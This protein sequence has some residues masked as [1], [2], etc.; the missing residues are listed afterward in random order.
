VRSA[1][2]VFFS[3]V[4]VAA[5]LTP[6]AAVAVATPAFADTSG[7]TPAWTPPVK[8][9]GGGA[10]PSIRVAPDGRTAAYIAAPSALGSNFWRVEESVDSAGITH[11]TPSDAQQP[12]L[13]TGGGD[14]EI[15]VGQQI[16]PTS[17]C[18]PIAYSGLHNIDLFDNFTV[19]TSTDCGKTFSLA[20]PFG[21]QNTLTDR[22]WQTFDGQLTNHL[23]YHKVDTGQI[24][25]SVS[26]DGG[27]TYV[28]L[29]TPAGATGLIDAAHA[30][31]I[32][33]V[34]IGNILTDESRPVSGKTYPISGEQVHTLWA[35]FAGSRDAADA[36]QGAAASGGWDHL[37]TIYVARSDDGGL[38]WTD[39]AAYTTGASETRELDLIFPV[40]TEDT[41]GNLYS[42]W[43][44]G[45]LIQYVVSTDA[46][47][48]WS[49]PYTVNPGESGAKATDGT[50]DLFPWIAGGGP[51][52]LDVVWYHGQGGDTTGYRNV[53]T[54]D[55]KW[56]VAFAQLAD[57]TAV[58]SAGAAAPTV[59]QR[60]LAVTP[61][62]H[63]GNV[64][65]N[66]TT[67]GITDNGDRT[68]LD[69]F[70]VAIDAAGRANIAYAADQGS[71]GTAHVEYTR[72]NS[73]QSV[74][75]G[76][77]ITPSAF[78]ADDGAAACT[79]DGTITD[80]AG[81][82]TGAVLVTSTPTPSQA[83]L[84]VTRAWI[85][86]TPATA[87]DPESLTFHI[88]VTNLGDTGGQ[89]FRFY[90]SYGTTQY[91]AIM[92]RDQTGAKAYS[93]SQNGTTGASSLKTITGSFD[94]AASEVTA[95]FRL[96]DFNTAASPSTAMADGATLGGLQVLA[97]RDAGVL[98]ATSD[99]ATGTCPYIVG[100][101]GTP[102]ATLPET[103][104]AVLLPIAGVLI[105]GWLMLR[106]RQERA[107]ARA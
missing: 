42:A 37:D 30:Y 81:D 33:N 52:R 88:H 107:T 82:A 77:V 65:N 87:T 6:I 96:N 17:G 98:T 24:V 47:Q 70:Q 21:T 64:C 5:L 45:N 38:T 105:G 25:D 55:T 18:A 3:A 66:G 104:V 106:R 51:G 22:Q 23:I 27:K 91:L 85:S 83:D 43:T 44:D 79:P 61:T 9:A 40:L 94:T 54:G 75:D 67:C 63:T 7:S 72:Q 71:A 32:Q 99:T 2:R 103:P 39:T 84:D 69:F 74:Y 31:T 86:T 48:S 78:A 11:F 76:S 56:T 8:L 16:D 62:M 73:G 60:D 20:N 49:K 12:D 80:P 35:T 59:V 34:K 46:G 53:G 28:T 15:S 68:L 89:Y 95:T 41:A 97:Q 101:V 4:P 100:T 14:A 26:Y 36:V 93:L 29:G 92:S 90:F 10:E 58:D 19:A 1:L 102:A 50:A 57:A 13:G